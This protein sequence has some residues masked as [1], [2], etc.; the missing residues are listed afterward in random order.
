MR[1]RFA[2][3][4]LRPKSLFDKTEEP[5]ANREDEFDDLITVKIRDRPPLFLCR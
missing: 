1:R 5:H 3:P 4:L 2:V